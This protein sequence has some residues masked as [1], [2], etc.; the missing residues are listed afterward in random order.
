MKTHLLN[1]LTP[2]HLEHLENRTR[3]KIIEGED[4]VKEIDFVKNGY[5]RYKCHIDYMKNGAKCFIKKVNLT[6]G[7]EEE[8]NKNGNVNS[9]YEIVEKELGWT[10]NYT[11]VGFLSSVTKN[12]IMMKPT[13]RSNYISLWMPSLSE[14]LDGY[15]IASKKYNIMKRQVDMLNMDI[16]KLIS[17]DY[18]INIANLQNTYDKLVKEGENLNNYLIKCESYDNLLPNTNSYDLTVEINDFVTKCKEHRLKYDDIIA[19]QRSLDRYRGEDGKKHLENDLY[20]CEKENITLNSNLN[21]LDDNLFN[22]RSS[23]EESKV[24]ISDNTV[25][26]YFDITETIR[27]LEKDL[28]NTKELIKRKINEEP[29]L[30]QFSLDIDSNK[31]SIYSNLMDNINNYYEKMVNLLNLDHIS[32]NIAFSAYNDT[33]LTIK[34]GLQ[35]KYDVLENK[36]LD[37]SNEIYSLENSKINSDIID[38]KPDLCNLKCGILDEL[39]R[40]LSPEKELNSLKLQLGQ[41][42]IEKSEIGSKIEENNNELNKHRVVHE[43]SQEINNRIYKDALLIAELPSFINNIFKNDDIFIIISKIPLLHSKTRDIQDFIALRSKLNTLNNTLSSTLETQEMLKMKNDLYE[44]HKQLL[45]KYDTIIKDRESI[46]GRL[47]RETDKLARL[48]SIN[49]IINENKEKISI[50]NDISDTLLG[51]KKLLQKMAK[52]WHFKGIFG[53]NM[54]ILRV[55]KAENEGMLESIRCELDILKNKKNSRDTL[56]K[57]RNN[58]IEGMKKLEIIVNIWSPKVGYPAWEMEEFLDTLLEQTNKDLESAWGS[59]LKINSFNIGPTEFSIAIDREGTIIPDAVE[60]SDGERA[61]L[62]LALSFAVIEINLRLKPYNVL[63]L[64]EVDGPL[65]MDRRRSFLDIILNRIKALNCGSVFAISHNSEFDTVESDLIVLRG[66]DLNNI[67]LENKN[68]LFRI[69]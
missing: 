15:K 69:E 56:I 63:R 29:L 41:F 40:I 68:I 7:E 48:K 8:L 38:L 47:N 26:S 2:C 53:Q 25:K 59:T 64:D 61:I 62:A 66:A 22:I 14:F 17:V 33:L 18:E 57:A 45:I 30:N 42:I 44:K 5:I 67:N 23:I 65:D 51:R 36:I 39:L 28:N 50:Y 24:E 12:I 37:I 11:N 21:S 1:S 9:Y 58:I 34:H 32:S 52:N 3:S 54:A 19:T 60:C 4:G 6:T 43:Y 27:I 35:R 13:E 49:T 31:I 16:N 55:K 46:I 20:D 10:K